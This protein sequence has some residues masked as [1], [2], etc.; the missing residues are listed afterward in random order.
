MLL[1]ICIPTYNRQ[2]NLYNC[3]NSIKIAS[4]IVSKN[5]FE[6]CISDNS[7][8]D[9]SENICKKFNKF[10]NLKYKKQKKTLE[11]QNFI[12]VTKMAK[13]EFIWLIGD[14]DTYYYQMV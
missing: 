12:N 1:S 13:G 5:L 8:N 14:D 7:S 3:L 11:F 9:K 4:K 6:V 2:L 10:I